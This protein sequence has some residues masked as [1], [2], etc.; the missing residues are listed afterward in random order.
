MLGLANR[1]QRVRGGGWKRKVFFWTRQPAVLNVIDVCCRSE[2]ADGLGCMA[3]FLRSEGLCLV[4]PCVARVD[5]HPGARCMV[6][7]GI[8]RVVG[9]AWHRQCGDCSLLICPPSVRRV[10]ARATCLRPEPVAIIVITSSFTIISVCD[11]SFRTRPRCAVHAPRL[12]TVCSLPVD[13]LHAL[14]LRD[15]C[16]C[17][18]YRDSQS[19]G[20]VHAERQRA[21]NRER[22]REEKQWSHSFVGWGHQNTHGKHRQW[23]HALFG[24]GRRI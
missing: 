3:L 24:P 18:R 14:G 13:T 12:K 5:V 19:T 22:T 15:R 7:R 17:L 20:A 21:Q 10:L 9:A 1:L 4:L 6:A 11:V 2:A 8:G 23:G 16:M